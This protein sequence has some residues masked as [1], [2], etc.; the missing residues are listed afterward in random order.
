MWKRTFAGISVQA[1]QQLSGANV[2]MYYVVYVFDMA[3]FT[4]DV[5]LK[6]SGVEYAVFII[7][8]FVS[9]HRVLFALLLIWR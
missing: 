8:T 5:G 3:G 4:G 2:M 6:S 1:W 7:G 9:V